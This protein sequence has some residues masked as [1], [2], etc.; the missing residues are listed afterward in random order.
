MAVKGPVRISQ[1]IIVPLCMVM[2]TAALLAFFERLPVRGPKARVFTTSRMPTGEHFFTYR[3]RT[4]PMWAYR[5]LHAVPAIIWSVGMP[6]QHVD[7][8]R[9][10][11]PALH[12][13]AG[14]VLLSISL[15]LSITGAWLF[16]A[17]HA[18]SHENLLHLHNLNGLS[19]VPWPTFEVTTWLVVPFYW[20]TMYKTA[21]TARA[22]DFARHRRWAVMHTI[23]A[24]VISIERASLILL[25][26]VGV[27]MALLPQAVVHDFFGVGYTVEEMAEAELSVFAFANI[28]ALATALLWLRYEFGRAGGSETAGEKA[29]VPAENKRVKKGK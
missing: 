12:R 6:L 22:R 27:A 4:A 19:P 2:I 11:W 23:W 3:Q 26:A 21:A 10:K 7:S 16:I 14:Y 1:K 9:R 24:S 20:L 8:L 29:P 17:K 28:I 25:Y 15:L 13:S 18:Y 5:S